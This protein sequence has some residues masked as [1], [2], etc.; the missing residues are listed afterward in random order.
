MVLHKYLDKFSVERER[1]AER[2]RR[3]YDDGERTAEDVIGELDKLLAR[4]TSR[5]GLIQGD[6]N[7]REDG[8]RISE[9][10]AND[11][12]KRNIKGYNEVTT[13]R[14][15]SEYKT[16]YIEYRQHLIEE[17]RHQTEIC[18]RLIDVYTSAGAESIVAVLTKRIEEINRK[19]G[20][21][22]GPVE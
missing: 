11:L 5:S 12:K 21:L 9:E 2:L 14:R 15:I 4:S 6:V 16:E 13:R 17:Y 22:I 3:L 20:D 8:I 19:Y 10:A 1:D 7:F 18:R